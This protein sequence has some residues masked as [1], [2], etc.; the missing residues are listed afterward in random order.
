MRSMRTL[1]SSAFAVAG[2]AGLASPVLGAHAAH[3]DPVGFPGLNGLLLSHSWKLGKTL[4]PSK[5]KIRNARKARS[6]ERFWHLGT[7]SSARRSRAA[8]RGMS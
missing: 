2:V 4:E 5:S 7:S 6:S 8:P 1:R 3:A